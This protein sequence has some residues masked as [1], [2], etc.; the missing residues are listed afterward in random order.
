VARAA[1]TSEG[2]RRVRVMLR[3]SPDHFRPNGEYGDSYGDGLSR[4]ARRRFA[5]R[6]ARRHGLTLVGDWPMPLLGVD[7]FIMTVPPTRSPEMEAADLS[8]DPG[9]AW[10]EPMQVYHA[11]SAP[12]VHDDPLFPAQPAARQ[13]RL[14]DMHQMA[15]GRNVSVAIIDS[16]IELDH[17]DLVGQIAWVEDFLLNH[18]ATAEAHGT[19]VAGVIGARADNGVG[20]VG[21]APRS[22]LMA[23]RACWQGRAD[24]SGPGATLCDSLSLAQALHF[25]IEHD[26][27][28][29]NL[30]LSGPPDRLLARLVDIA[31]GRGEI[32]VGAYDRNLPAGGFPASNPGVVAVIDEPMASPTAGVYIAPGR[33]VPTT[34]PGGRW[35]LVNGSSYAAAHVS[36]LFAL[37][38]EL[39]PRGP[40]T[41][42]VV[43]T[44][45]GAGLIDACASLLRVSGP[46]DC[47]CARRSKD[48]ANPATGRVGH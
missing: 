34:Q 22:R 6:L 17:P 45:A 4:A 11:R 48:A 9:V 21:V 2:D 14:A 7:C 36:G 33:D 18:P 8:R 40:L 3:L 25:A 41:S 13:W 26:A 31:I 47:A 29:I 20:I 27:Q 37:M 46:C 5:D 24:P 32:V 1:V 10:S 42:S 23:L 15:T 30:S 39:S 19:G 44:R 28:V 12:M 43:A 38:R 35:F 16:K